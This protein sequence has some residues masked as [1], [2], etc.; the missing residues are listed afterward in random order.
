MAADAHMFARISW[1]RM[2][3]APP[4][5]FRRRNNGRKLGDRATHRLVGCCSGREG[6]GCRTLDTAEKQ[7]SYGSM[8][9]HAMTLKA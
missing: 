9:L 1:G 5:L 6:Q 8:L 3:A 2:L 4:R 7:Y